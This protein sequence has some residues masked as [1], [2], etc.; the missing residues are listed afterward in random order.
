MNCTQSLAAGIGVGALAM[1]LL[2]PDRGNRRRAIL[3][4]KIISTVHDTADVLEDA[5]TDARNRGYGLIAEVK[6]RFRHDEDIPEQKLVARIRSRMGRV[7]SHPHSV[8]VT[9][10]NG[11][12]TLTGSILK[13]EVPRLL[14]VIEGIPGVQDVECRLSVS[15][16][17]GNV[18]GLQGG[19]PREET[20]EFLQSNWSPAARL[21]AGT[22]G[23]ALAVTGSARR[24]GFGGVLALSGL[25]LL[26]RSITNMDL[27]R[28]VGTGVAHLGIEIEKTPQI[29]VPAD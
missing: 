28:L 19:V 4:D 25:A 11:C 1:Y 12:V 6:G 9:C 24:D 16:T 5:I 13:S 15:E 7:I 8:H 2:D 23:G 26:V 10:E 22:L 20:F 29:A 3:G 27:A 14:S 21:L 17:R 18:P